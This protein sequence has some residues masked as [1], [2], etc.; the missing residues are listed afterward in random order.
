LIVAQE[1]NGVVKTKDLAKVKDSGKTKV[2]ELLDEEIDDGHEADTEDDPQVDRRPSALDTSTGGSSPRDGEER[3]QELG[4]R[5]SNPHRTK[6]IIDSH[7]SNIITDGQ[8]ISTEMVDCLTPS[9]VNGLNP[10]S[11]LLLPEVYQEEGTLSMAAEVDSGVLGGLRGAKKEEGESAEQATPLGRSVANKERIESWV[12]QSVRCVERR[13]RV[14]SASSAPPSSPVDAAKVAEDDMDEEGGEMNVD[15]EGEEEEE[16]E[17]AREEED[18]EE[19]DVRVERV[20]DQQASVKTV[21]VGSSSSSDYEDTCEV[22]PQDT[23]PVPSVE[24]LLISQH[25]PGAVT[26][27]SPDASK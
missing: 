26:L 10:S 5:A 8:S 2:V 22:L 17:E 18:V 3:I 27:L 15:D 11:T 7:P 20:E 16:E 4:G 14:Q 23:V 25:P 6:S 19:E 12:A 9:S 24:D 21:E 1:R 13:L